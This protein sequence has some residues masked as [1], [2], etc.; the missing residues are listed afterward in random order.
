[1]TTY[2]GAIAALAV[3]ATQAA[4]ADFLAPLP[5][6]SSGKPASYVSADFNGDG[7]PDLAVLNQCPTN[8]S[9][10]RIDIRL[11]KGDG[12]FRAGTSFFAGGM[13]PAVIAAGDFNGDGKM[14]LVT[15]NSGDPATGMSGGFSILLGNGDGTFQKPKVVLLNPAPGF[16]SVTVGDVN[17]DGKLDVVG[18]AGHNIA[19]IVM[20]GHGDGTFSAPQFYPI[21]GA[22][23]SRVILADFNHDQKLDI[24]ATVNAPGQS[25][26]ILLNQGN[27]VFANPVYYDS[28]QNALSIATADFNGDGNPDLA[29][30]GV[31]EVT[32]LNGSANGTFHQAVTAYSTSSV[33]DV[34]AGDLNN[35]G[36]PDLFVEG[37]N[38]AAGGSPILSVLLGKGNGTFDS[39]VFYDSGATPLRL[40]AEDFNGDKNL[41]LG[42]LNSTSGG[43]ILEGNGDGTLRS[44]ASVLL[45]AGGLATSLYGI[46]VADMNGDGRLDLIAES[47]TG[48]AQNKGGLSVLLGNGDGTFQAPVTYALP[49]VLEWFV[50]KDLNGDLKPDV[51]A[52]CQLKPG[53]NATLT[54]FLNNGSGGLTALAPMQ[55]GGPGMGAFSVAV[56]DFNGDKK[57]D[58]AVSLSGLGAQILLGKGDGTFRA[59]VLLSGPFSALTAAAFRP[60]G[61][62]DLVAADP[63]A[64]APALDVFLGKGDG[65]FGKPAVYPLAKPALALAT[66]LFNADTT[67]D[68]AATSQ[69]GFSIL[70][71][72][73][74]GTFGAAAFTKVSG[75]DG[76][77]AVADFNSDGKQDLVLGAANL[78]NSQVVSANVSVLLG[79]GDGTFGA[80]VNY[81]VEARPA[82][83][84][85][86]DLNGDGKPDIV[87]AIS[88]NSYFHVLLHQ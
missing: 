32:I 14:D 2:R 87:A 85:G 43:S 50:I 82:T 76:A 12:T 15:G 88:G 3:L 29:V 26:A 71:N 61:V 10:C 16:G 67:M 68:I 41:D 86:V 24:A 52:I 25:V 49:P 23:A 21:T 51:A 70:L 63:T 62:Q 1:M 77:M 72:N 28:G 40:I 84:S 27:G 75:V 38:N 64:A 34:A 45:K 11:G 20:L 31:T 48:A 81:A 80:P 5:F 30:G 13:G 7:K 33:F 60:S 66:S 73:G 74:D 6:T 56:A 55:L 58:L 83:V 69:G 35:D 4:A 57:A 44:P 9:G 46:R 65:T 36:H 47:L 53:S 37:Q 8:P 59:G 17:G 54:V 79:N 22:V 19:V 39:P 18:G 78:Q 42:V